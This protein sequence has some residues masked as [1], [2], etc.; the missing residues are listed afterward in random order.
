MAFQVLRTSSGLPFQN[1]AMSTSLVLRQSQRFTLEVADYFNNYDSIF[2]RVP[3]RSF[4]RMKPGTD[5][6][7]LSE[8]DIFPNYPYWED[9]I[10][11]A[12]EL[13]AFKYYYSRHSGRSYQYLFVT[14]VPVKLLLIND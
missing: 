4:A 8:E 3:D 11:L 14:N 6:L 13:K 9:S 7:E 10:L 5:Y 1:A 12:A 2:L